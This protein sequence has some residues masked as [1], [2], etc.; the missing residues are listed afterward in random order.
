MLDENLKDV[1]DLEHLAHP[2][3]AEVEQGLLLM[4]LLG[5]LKDRILVLALAVVHVERQQPPGRTAVL[6][7][8]GDGAACVIPRLAIVASV[9]LHGG[10]SEA[11][12]VLFVRVCCLTRVP[13]LLQARDERVELAR[14]GPTAPQLAEQLELEVSDG[15]AAL[16][17]VA[18]EYHVDDLLRVEPIPL[19]LNVANDLRLPEQAQSDVCSKLQVELLVLR[20]VEVRLVYLDAATPSED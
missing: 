2:A 1:L 14:Y 15:F 3:G 18:V 4:L 6:V 17:V 13:H 16:G 19:H 20:H 7:H 5:S 9:D 10:K 11:D 8:N 12:L